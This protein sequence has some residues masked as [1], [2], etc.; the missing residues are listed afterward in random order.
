MKQSPWVIGSMPVS[1]LSSVVLPA[2]L[3]PRIAV[4]AAGK[5]FRSRRST[6]WEQHTLGQYR[7]LRRSSSSS[8][9]LR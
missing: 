6:A 9:E 8:S 1:M 7:T 2:P 5:I 3:C 4:T